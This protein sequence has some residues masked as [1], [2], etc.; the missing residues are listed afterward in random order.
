MKYVLRTVLILTAIVGLAW[1][2]YATVYLDDT[3]ADGT[4]NNTALP[5]NS[6]WYASTGS[7]LTATTNSMNLAVSGSAI[8]A[9]TYFTT[10]TT[11]Y[12]HLDVGDTLTEIGRA[13]CRVRVD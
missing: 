3:W 11:S 10:S 13:S 9:L 12:V 8:M 6:A 5:S 2:G 1:P 4:R 7:S